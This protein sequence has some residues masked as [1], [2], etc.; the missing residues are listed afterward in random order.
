MKLKA[1]S[2]PIINWICALLVVV[3]LVM[4]FTPYW[5]YTAKET[6]EATGV[7]EDVTKVASISGYIWIPR[8]HKNLTAEF[9][10]IYTHINE[11]NGITDKD[12]MVKFWVND[13]S[14]MP[15]LILA[16]AVICILLSALYSK[17]PLTA[18]LAA[19]LG[20][21]TANAFFISPEYGYFILLPEFAEHVIGNPLLYIILGIVTAVVG[22]A[23]V[24]WFAVNTVLK[25]KKAK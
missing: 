23:G 7:R 3:M 21:V 17:Y 5:T 24:L 11:I 18:L 14:V 4:L 1:M 6:N 22:F 16:G 15:V 25:M 20:I 19:V 8:E 2:T 10:K 9:E 12:Y 13:L